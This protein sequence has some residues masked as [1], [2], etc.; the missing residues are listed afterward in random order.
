MS[1]M[2]DLEIGKRALKF[3]LFMAIGIGLSAVLP[4]I[5]VLIMPVA[6]GFG[7]RALVKG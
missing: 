7:I 3:W 2:S 1:V 4:P 5:T 6:A